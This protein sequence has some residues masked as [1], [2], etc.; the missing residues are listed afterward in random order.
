[1]D[2]LGTNV[3][4]IDLGGVNASFIPL[5]SNEGPCAVGITEE[6]PPRV[7]LI[8]S[9]QEKRTFSAYELDSR[10]IKMITDKL[11]PEVISRL[12]SSPSKEMQEVGNFVKRLQELQDQ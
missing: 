10:W 6:E 7:A 8:H 5:A 2:S 12:S 9:D 11:S 4:K 3:A 1:M